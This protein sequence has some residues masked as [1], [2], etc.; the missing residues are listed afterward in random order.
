MS[1]QH[2]NYLNDMSSDG[3]SE[4]SSSS[5]SS[6]SSENNLSELDDVDYYL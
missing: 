2:Q 6:S 4:H 1:T 5:S 3:E